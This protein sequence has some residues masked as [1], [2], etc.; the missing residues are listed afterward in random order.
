DES[1]NW[2]S[3]VKRVLVRTQTDLGRDCGIM[4]PIMLAASANTN[5]FDPLRVALMVALACKTP[6]GLALPSPFGNAMSSAKTIAPAT[7]LFSA[8]YIATMESDIKVRLI[9]AS[10]ASS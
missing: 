3:L 1:L 10:P 5:A 8:V 7:R 9:L 2:T 6:F 4:L